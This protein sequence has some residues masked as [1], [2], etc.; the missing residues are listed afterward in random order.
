MDI[1]I[2]GDAWL[3][4]TDDNRVQVNPVSFSIPEKV[5][6]LMKGL[7]RRWNSDLIVKLLSPQQDGAIL[8]IPLCNGR[9]KDQW[10]W[11]GNNKGIYSVKAGY[12][13]A[14]ESLNNH[15]SVVAGCQLPTLSLSEMPYSW[16]L[17]L[18]VHPMHPPKLSSKGSENATRKA[19]GRPEFSSKDMVMNGSSQP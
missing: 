5:H 18:V 1:R 14:C 8:A 2:E 12:Y 15:R 6:E 10:I 7:G 9:P 13:V 3:A 19:F 4:G 16:I 11:R 17:F